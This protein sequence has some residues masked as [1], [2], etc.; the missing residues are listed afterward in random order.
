MAAKKK[1]LEEKAAQLG[2]AGVRDTKF[3]YPPERKAGRI[4][5]TGPDAVPELLKVLREEAK[6]L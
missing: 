1:P 6:V 4:I 3:S 5:G 2:Q